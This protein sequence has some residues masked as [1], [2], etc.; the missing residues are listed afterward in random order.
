MKVLVT[1]ANGFIGKNL[2]QRLKEEKDLEIIKYDKEDNFSLIEENIN[3]FDF[4]FHLAGINRPQDNK[5]FYEGNSDLSKN[6]V[7]LLIKNKSKT[8]IILTSSIQAIKD[9]DYG[10]SKKLAEEYFSK[11][12]YSYIYRLSNV[13]GK[14]CKPNY[15]SVVAT[16]CNNIATGIELEINDPNYEIDLIYIDDIVEEFLSIMN[17]N[18]PSVEKDGLY[19]I[20]PV[21][22]I[23]IGELAEIIKSFKD[24]IS[25][26][27][28]PK[29]GDEFIKKLFSTYLSYVDLDELVFS[30]KVNRDD[31]GSFVELVRSK[32]S[33]QF[34]VSTSKPG[35]IRGNHY[36]HTKMEKFIVIKGKAKIKFRHVITNHIKEFIVDESDIKIVNIPVGY[37]HSIENISDSE[38]ILLLWCNELFDQNKPDTFFMEV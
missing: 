6:I 35:V 38:M 13:F 24:S 11:Y 15:N 22:R 30:P 31:R 4:I 27:M 9:N 25:S 32:D 34:S 12:K 14:W 19:Y 16:F 18:K 3:S 10:K 5:E 37:T 2:C 26:I 7:D 17:K 21:K 28:V 29:T 8:P 23:S 33:G 20:E 36:H 1:G